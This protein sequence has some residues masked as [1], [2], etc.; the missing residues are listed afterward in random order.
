MIC[1]KVTDTLRHGNPQT[2][3]PCRKTTVLNPQS[4]GVSDG[5]R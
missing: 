5:R 3:H 2:L 1:R 4:F